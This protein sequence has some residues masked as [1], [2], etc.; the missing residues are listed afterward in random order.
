MPNGGPDNCGRCGFNQ[1]NNG[2]W[3]GPGGENDAPGFCTLRG[4]DI[5][6]P[7][8]TYCQ[9][10]HTRVPEPVGPIYTSIYL[11]GYQRIPYYYRTAPIGSAATCIVCRKKTDFGIVVPLGEEPAG[12]CGKEHY[13]IWWTDGMRK[14]LAA[15]KQIGESAYDAMYDAHDSS[16]ATARYSDAKEAFYDAIA[17]SRE[18]EWDEETSAIEARLTHIKEVFR[19]QFT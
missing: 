13:L 16:T 11:D 6:N 4:F 2:A 19:R 10:Q 15:C 17:A 14:R 8:W 1:A 9:N 18:L 12:F 3:P 7:L 5:T